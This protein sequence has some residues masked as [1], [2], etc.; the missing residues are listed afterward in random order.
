MVNPGNSGGPVLDDA[1]RVVGVTASGIRGSGVN[2]AIPVDHV[3]RLLAK[4]D[5]TVTGPDVIPW[6]N[7]FDPATLLV[8]VSPLPQAYR[9]ARL[10]RSVRP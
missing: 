9:H 6:K 7:R 5:L 2:F 3:L 8:R 10:P 1:G 4:P